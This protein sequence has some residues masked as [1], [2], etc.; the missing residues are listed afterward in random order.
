MPTLTITNFGGGLTRRNTGDI[1]SGLTKFESSWG[2]DPFSKPGNLTWFEQPTSILSLDDSDGPIVA[3]KQRSEAT[4]NRVYAVANDRN[5]YK[6]SLSSGSSPGSELDTPSVVGALINMGGTAMFENG[7]DIRFYGSTEKIF[8]SSR[9]IQK[10]N[11]DGSGV[12]SIAG[13]EASGVPRPMATF[14]GKLYYGNANNIGEIDSTELLVT[15]DRLSPAL[16]SGFFV[17]DLDP[18]PDGNY[19]QITATR[20]RPDLNYNPL[21]TSQP[22]QSMSESY[23]FLWNGIDAGVT[24]QEFYPGIQLTASEIMGEEDNSFGYEQS[25]A[26]I[27]SGSIKELALPN[28]LPPFFG[29]TFGVSN[30]LGFATVEYVPDDKGYRGAVYNYGQ[31]DSE[32]RPGLY[33]TLRFNAVTAGSDVVVVQSAKNVSNHIYAH[34]Y[35][36]LPSSVAASGKMYITATEA[37]ALGAPVGP[38][39]ILKFNTNPIGVGSIV[40]GVHETQTQLFSK[41]TAIKEVRVYT[42]PLVGGNDFT[43]DLIGSGGSVM[44]GGSQRFEVNTGSVATSTDMVHFNPAMSPTYALGIRITNAS[45]TGVVNWTAL[46]VEV[47]TEPAGK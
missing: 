13:T 27:L 11:F 30:M 20:N 24:S 37:S 44:S 39:R 18:T 28:N 36:G 47:D 38:H 5:L 23:K 6:I 33:R 12:T 21:G 41:K 22:D 43:V 2:Y 3:I 35:R 10:I 32:T 29:A 14:L 19:L 9:G 15:E 1:D 16:P 45:V 26:A 8:V 40:A 17:Q 34:S 4:G 46:K 42:E 25:G 31:Y 7:G